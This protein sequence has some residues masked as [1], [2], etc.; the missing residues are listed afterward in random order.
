MPAQ[1]RARCGDSMI[2]LIHIGTD[3]SQVDV[4]AMFHPVTFHRA[5][6]TQSTTKKLNSL[7]VSATEVNIGF[8]LH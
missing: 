4:L 7:D 1:L 5:C 3:L 8:K 6:G 2:W